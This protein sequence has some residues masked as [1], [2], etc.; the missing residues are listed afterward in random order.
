[1]LKQNKLL[2]INMQESLLVPSNIMLVKG[3]HIQHIFMQQP[4]QYLCL[5]SM[6]EGRDKDNP[7]NN[8]KCQNAIFAI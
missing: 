6:H 7:D 1:M 8:K 2:C 5:A 3:G 4:L